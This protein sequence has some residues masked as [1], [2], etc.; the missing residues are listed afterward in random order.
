MT[1]THV[2]DRLGDHLEGDLSLDER[3]RVDAHLA[4]CTECADELRE[5]RAGL[6]R[7]QQ[8]ALQALDREHLV[9]E[10]MRKLAG[11]GLTP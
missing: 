1:D 10:L 9:A 11:A 4:R 2:R 5:L 8:Q 7:R 6:L 3:S